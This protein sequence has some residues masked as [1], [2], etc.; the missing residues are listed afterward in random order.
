MFRSCIL[1]TVCTVIYANDAVQQQTASVRAGGCASPQQ[2]RR[3][4][5]RGNWCW[6]LLCTANTLPAADTP[7]FPTSE[8]ALVGGGGT[9]YWKWSYDVR[10][11]EI[12]H[13]FVCTYVYMYVYL[14]VYMNVC[15]H[16]GISSSWEVEYLAV[17]IDLNLWSALVKCFFGKTSN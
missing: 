11:R 5:G 3:E 9:R 15:V 16:K 8:S 7:T 14:Y 4:L 1:G 6:C 13:M 10:A 17:Y 12:A 2:R